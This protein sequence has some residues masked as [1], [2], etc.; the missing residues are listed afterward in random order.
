LIQ[1]GLSRKLS[2]KDIGVPVL[3]SN[4]LI[5]NE[6]NLDDISYWY[7]KDSKGAKIENYFLKENDLLINFINSLSQ[8]GKIALFKNELKRNTIFTTNLLRLNFN[9]KIYIDFMYFYF[10]TGKYNNYIQVIT[11]PAVNQASFTTVDLKKFNLK[12]PSLHEQKKI[13]NFL[14]SINH[15]IKLLN[16]KLGYFKDFKKYCFQ[17]L[18]SEKLR[19]NY[20]NS[21]GFKNK[22]DFKSVKLESLIKKGKAGGTPKSSIGRYYKGN[23]PFLSISDMTMQ[24]KYIT[25]TSKKI[26]KEAINDSSAWI[27]PKNSLLYSI[28][29][30][31]GFVSINKIDLSTSQAIFGIILKDNVNIDYIY[32]Y[33]TYFKRFV[34]KFIETGTQ[35]NLNKNILYNF[36]IKIPNSIEEQEKI[37][38]FLSLIDK[39]IDLTQNQITEMEKFKKGLLQQMFVYLILYISIFL[40][41]L[42]FKIILN[43]L[44]YYF[45]F[46]L[47]KVLEITD[48]GAYDL[49]DIILM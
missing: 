47:F 39:K 30:S 15:K 25:F 17:N 10:Q 24:G 34:H 4:N 8:I 22:N 28:Y 11:K 19:F 6:L 13:A 43:K 20:L 26:T 48:K 29:A 38:S 35:G 16:K 49:I 14:N 7:I 33:L 31:I 18:F 9:S 27:I 41:L 1:S 45:I 21:G 46:H 5:N 44:E 12:V 2:Q 32:Y 3:R 37:A 23:I 42:F 40:I 36:I